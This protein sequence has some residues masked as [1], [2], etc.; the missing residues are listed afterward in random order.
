MVGVHGHAPSAV[1]VVILRDDVIKRLPLGGS[2][3]RRHVA[4]AQVHHASTIAGAGLIGSRRI[5][6]AIHGGQQV[7]AGSVGAV[8]SCRERVVLIDGRV[9]RVAAVEAVEGGGWRAAAG[10]YRV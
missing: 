3:I 1:R 4:A 8:G 2:A 7:P 6:V 9:C 5:A 10:G